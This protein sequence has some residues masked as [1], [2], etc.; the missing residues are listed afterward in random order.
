M[1]SNYTALLDACV[2]YPAQLR[3]L[4]LRL[5]GT[6]LFRARWTD[7]IHDEWTAAVSNRTGIDPVKLARTRSLM[8]QSVPD[9]LVVGYEPLIDTLHLPD[10]DDRHVLAAAIF[11]H[12]DVI[13]TQNTKDFPASALKPYN[14]QAQHPDDFVF[15]QLDLNP[16]VVLRVLREQRM[17]LKNPPLQS[18]TFLKTLEVHLPLSVSILRDKHDFI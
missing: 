3:D 6:G 18:E 4:L 13:V 8:N 5:A 10:P 14:I 11:A 9:C 15:Y 1:F 7:Q 12:A 17:S 2:L 16:D